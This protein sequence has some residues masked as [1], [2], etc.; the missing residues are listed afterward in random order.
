MNNGDPSTM[1]A[2]E[3]Q[4]VVNNH[5]QTLIDARTTTGER[6]QKCKHTHTHNHW[7]CALSPYAV[8]PAVN[9]LLFNLQK[10]HNSCKKPNQPTRLRWRARVKVEQLTDHLFG[11]WVNSKG[12][13][14]TSNKNTLLCICGL[15]EG[16]SCAHFELLMTVPAPNA[17][18]PVCCSRQTVLGNMCTMC[19]AAMPR[20]YIFSLLWS[21]ARQGTDHR[22]ARPSGLF[23]VSGRR[24]E[25]Y[26]TFDGVWE[27]ATIA[28]PQRARANRTAGEGPRGTCSFLFISPQF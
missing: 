15:V 12:T 3:N 22:Q 14:N 21:P 28:P 17:L 11:T 2:I 6:K 7:G 10:H 8:L 27:A 20:Q 19:G 13:R 24:T 16:S 9:N 25:T 26:T 4:N 18:P 1:E 23:G 5:W